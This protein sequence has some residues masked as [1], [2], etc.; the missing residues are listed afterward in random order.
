MAF[1]G[2]PH[3]QRSF[4]LTTRRGVL[5]PSPIVYDDYGACYAYAFAEVVGAVFGYEESRRNDTWPP[6]HTP[7]SARQLIDDMPR[8]YLDGDS[9]NVSGIYTPRLEL[10]VDYIKRYGIAREEDYAAA[11]HNNNVV[12]LDQIPRLRPRVLEDII[13]YGDVHRHLRRYPLVASIDTHGDMLYHL[14]RHE[15]HSWRGEG[16]HMVILTG[17]GTI[18]DQKVYE[19]KNSWGLGFA[20]NGY[21]LVAREAVVDIWK[22]SN[23]ELIQPAEQE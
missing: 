5:S 15:I 6:T 13:Y 10:V 8:R 11:L 14:Q 9:E 12:E 7:L 17:Y 2:C 23:V 16:N 21:G 18:A 3:V 1:I 19:F 20:S 4:S 22:P